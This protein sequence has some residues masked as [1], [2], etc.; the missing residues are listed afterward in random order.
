MVCHSITE[1]LLSNPDSSYNWG[2]NPPAS[3]PNVP[4]ALPQQGFVMP[5]PLWERAGTIFISPTLKDILTPPQ[6]PQKAQSWWQRD[7]LDVLDPITL[8]PRRCYSWLRITSTAS[9]RLFT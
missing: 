7:V 3:L 9:A 8:P 4:G 5:V 1:F 2:R 6:A